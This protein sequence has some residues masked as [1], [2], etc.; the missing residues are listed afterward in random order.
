[1]EIEKSFEQK[2]SITKNIIERE[3]ERIDSLLYEIQLNQK[4][5]LDISK[6]SPP[7]AQKTFETYIDKSARHK[8]DVVFI[9]KVDKPVWLNAS[10]PVPDVTPILNKIAALSRNFLT[11]AKI[12]RFESNGTDLT[13][14]F[15]SKKIILGNGDVIGVVVAGTI[16]NDNFLLL[17]K[18]KQQT[19]SPLVIFLDDKEL[20]ASSIVKGSEKLKAILNHVNHVNHDIQGDLHSIKV[21]SKNGGSALMLTHFKLEFNGTATSIKL[22]FAMNDNILN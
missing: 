5:F 2:Y 1:M 6:T 9:A 19:Q 8:C 10:S 3:A 4:L 15:K 18:I 7:Q 21:S 16:L 12:V 11:T 13:G 14:I 22:I 20:I 17:N